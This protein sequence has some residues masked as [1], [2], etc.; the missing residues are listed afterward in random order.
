MKG[1]Q[2]FKCIHCGVELSG[3]MKDGRIF[4]FDRG[5]DN[6][7]PPEP[8]VCAACVD[9]DVQACVVPATMGE[10]KELA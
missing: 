3:R 9:K 8:C 4:A 6:G 10:L 5:P 7:T 2:R 1:R